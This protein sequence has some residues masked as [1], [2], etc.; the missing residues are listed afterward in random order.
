MLSRNIDVRLA[1][2]NGSIGT[3]Q[4]VKVEPNN[5]KKIKEIYITFNKERVYMLGPVKTK[6]EI[7]NCA[8]VNREQFPICI[9][10][11]L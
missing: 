10:Y 7:T 4:K 5:R 3:M 1:L 9:A 6:F 11:A 8:Y 2:V